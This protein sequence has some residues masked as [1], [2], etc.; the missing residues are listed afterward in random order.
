MKICGRD[1]EAIRADCGDAICTSVYHSRD[2]GV[3]HRD[4]DCCSVYDDSSFDVGFLRVVRRLRYLH[5]STKPE[6]AFSSIGRAFFG[7]IGFCPP[8]RR[9]SFETERE[10]G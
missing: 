6:K 3:Q 9:S 2:S 1:A 4:A 5:V 8:G 10:R 7:K